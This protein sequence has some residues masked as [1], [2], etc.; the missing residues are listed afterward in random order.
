M[1]PGGC[2]TLKPSLYTLYLNTKSLNTSLHKKT[3][4]SFCLLPSDLIRRY[5]SIGGE[6]PPPDGKPTSPLL[7][8]SSGKLDPIQCIIDFYIYIHCCWIGSY[9]PELGSDVEP[10]HTQPFVDCI[11]SLCSSTIVPIH[12][13]SWVLLF[14]YALFD[15]IVDV[16]LYSAMLALFSRSPWGCTC[17]L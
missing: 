9:Y 3:K 2:T 10:G 11:A 5:R 1:S 16:C 8:R 17:S 14:W 4:I 13:L 7:L 12:L 15:H 6:K